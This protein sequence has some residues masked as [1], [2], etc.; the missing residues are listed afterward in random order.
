M[1]IGSETAQKISLE[2]FVLEMMHMP[3]KG[4]TVDQLLQLFRS[5]CLCD[6]LIEENIHFHETMYSRNLICRTPRFD[7]L[8]LCWQ[9]GQ[10][11]SVHDHCGSLNCTR[12]YRGQL[13]SRVFTIEDQPEPGRFVLGP[14]E[15]EK[16]G[17][18]GFAT[19]DRGQIH[20]LANTSDEPLVTIHVYAQPLKTMNVY[21]VDAQARERVTLRY[22]LEDDFA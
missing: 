11:S 19:V 12:V 20:Q 17:P 6:E 13:T 18:G 8:V 4:S 1:A 3:K 15:E 16:V 7:M 2:D 9:P 14:A 5:L 10:T 22:S 21:D